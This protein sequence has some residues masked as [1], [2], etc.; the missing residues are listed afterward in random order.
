[1]ADDSFTDFVLDQLR[2]L[3]NIRLRS[4]FGGYG[5][6][7][8]DLF[9]GIVYEGR[10]YFKTDENTRS[11]YVEAGMKPF[12]PSEKQTLKNY[13]EVPPDVL[14]D[15]E[16]LKEWARESIILADG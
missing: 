1:M 11:G 10:L 3:S 15:D 5:M 16:M 7:S 9:F 12:R 8:D 2:G 4:M 13:Y 14:E 6:Y